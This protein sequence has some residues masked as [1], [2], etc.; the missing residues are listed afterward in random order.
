VFPDGVF[1]LG[2]DLFLVGNGAP[3][4]IFFI[5]VVWCP[6]QD[7]ALIDVDYMVDD[8]GNQ[9]RGWRRCVVA[10]DDVVDV[11]VGVDAVALA[12]LAVII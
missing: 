5:V 9:C 7:P 6:D 8:F 2:V 10:L 3:A 12:E 4:T 11:D 1:D